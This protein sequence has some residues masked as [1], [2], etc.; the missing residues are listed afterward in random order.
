[1]LLQLLE[2]CL[3]VWLSFTMTTP[4]RES[5]REVI[6]A[7]AYRF[8]TT[9]EAALANRKM[10]NEQRYSGTFKSPI[11]ANY[12]E[13][14]YLSWQRECEWRYSVWS[15][16][17]DAVNPK[18][19]SL[20][21]LERLYVLRQLLGKEAFLDGWLPEPNAQYRFTCLVDK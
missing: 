2:G 19:G 1:M 20:Y 12:G 8:G 17:E 9:Y 3:A 15:S 11:L 18:C 4:L 7:D 16:L 6:L 5:D 13:S 14:G 21:R 10:A